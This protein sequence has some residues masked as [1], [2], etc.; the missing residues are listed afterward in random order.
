MP[1][2]K[3]CGIT[4]KEEAGML[5]ENQ[6]DYAGFVLFFPKSKRN[7]SMEQAEELVW[8]LK[9]KDS[10]IQAVAVTVSPTIEQI[11]Q[12]EAIFDKIQIHGNLPI[13]IEN[14]IQI[15]IWRAYN[16]KETESLTS[17]LMQTQHP[18]I[19]GYVIDSEIPGS[20]KTFAWHKTNNFGNI[21]KD[22]ILAGGLTSENVAYGIETYQPQVVDVSS[23]VEYPGEKFQGKD[24]QRIASFVQA[25]RAGKE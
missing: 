22:L 7:I 18:N 5:V 6:V 2:I 4:R 14:K 8:E 19:C 17:Q 10:R 13:E 15:P 23:S 3:I 24:P 11:R 12:I 1:K 9:K 16:I 21:D 20:G 25:V